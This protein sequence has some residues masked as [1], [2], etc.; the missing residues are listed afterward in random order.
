MAKKKKAKDA[1]EDSSQILRNRKAYHE[2][3]ILEKLECGI[4]LRGSEVKSLRNR[5]VNFAQTYCMIKDFQFELIGLHIAPY[6]Q[7]N[8]MNHDPDRTRRL[9]AHRREIIKLRRRVEEKGLTLVPLRLYWRHGRCK[10][11]IG[12]ARG[13]QLHDKRDSKRDK[14]L[15]RQMDRE[16]RGRG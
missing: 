16:I 3:E 1:Q 15:K 9:L 7:A 14:D 2:F 11:E 8:I 6:K 5:D 10:V 13:K 12:L 4:E